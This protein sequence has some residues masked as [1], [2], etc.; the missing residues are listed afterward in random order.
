MIEDL[1]NDLIALESQKML[2]QGAIN[3]ISNKIKGLKIIEEAE[4]KDE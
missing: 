1:E 2:I 3:Y 4:K